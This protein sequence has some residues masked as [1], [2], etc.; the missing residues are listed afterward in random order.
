MKDPEK[1]VK[2]AENGCKNIAAFFGRKAPKK[3][4]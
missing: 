1:S 4:V 3:R 2:E